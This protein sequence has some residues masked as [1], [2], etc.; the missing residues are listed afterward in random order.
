MTNASRLSSPSGQSNGQWGRRMHSEEQQEG[1]IN[2]EGQ[3]RLPP[4]S[5]VICSRN[6]RILL[7]DTVESILSGDEVPT[8]LIIV[9]QSDTPQL[10][11]EAM[12]DARGCTVRYL[13][14]RA[15][16]ASRA[17]NAGIAIARHA[18]LILVDDDMVATRTWFGLLVRA[19]V[20]LGSESVVTGSVAVGEAK[21]AH[22]FAPSTK[23]DTSRITYRGRIDEDVL[24]TGNMAVYRV[25][26]DV[27]GGFDERLGPGTDFPAAEDN[28]IGFRFLEAGYRIVYVPEALLY[29]QV[30]RP[31]AD[32]LSLRWAYGIG[33][34]GF[35][36]KHL[37]LKDRYMLTRMMRDI[38]SHAFS[39]F[40]RNR[41]EPRRACGDIALALGMLFG[42]MKW[43]A[44]QD[45]SN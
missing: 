4:S 42:A 16:G 25:S 19:L 33:R 17:R 28:D 8:E 18:V 35:Y 41:R 39:F 36:A 2:T 12:T 14:T 45:T 21:V 15:I 3:T 1:G 31:K 27:I 9:D 26:M 29:H 30:W 20:T 40:R 44:T 5:V 22:G 7:A 38:R 34:G 6:R 23:I 32:Y 10:R 24:F 11:F 13:W 43:R 37:R